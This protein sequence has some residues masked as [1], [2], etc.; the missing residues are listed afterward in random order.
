[1]VYIKS[2]SKTKDSIPGIQLDETVSQ[3]FALEDEDTKKA[4]RRISMQK[5]E[6]QSQSQERKTSESNQEN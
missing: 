2:I 6:K 5:L 3:Y 4:V 1:M